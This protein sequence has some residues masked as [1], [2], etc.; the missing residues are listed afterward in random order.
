MLDAGN[1][2]ARRDGAM[3]E[4]ALAKGA[5]VAT[6]EFLPGARV[7]RVFNSI[8]FKVFLSEA[9]R[10]G[11]RLA[12][13]VA[14]DDAQ[15]VAVASQLVTDAGFEPVVAGG[16]AKGKLFDSNSPLF[17]KTLTARELR[18]ALGVPQR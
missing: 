11:D 13:P 17:L 10:S 4:P 2:S 16:L 8:N 18:E 9:H 7:V 14:G 12:V 3:A 15:A 1:P 6:A 5:G